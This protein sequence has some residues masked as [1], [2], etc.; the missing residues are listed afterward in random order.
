MRRGRIFLYLILIIILLGVG[1]FVFYQ[2]LQQSGGAADAVVEATAIPDLVD[3]VIVTQNVKVGEVLQGDV[4]GVIP[5]PRGKEIPEMF[6]D[7]GA[8]VGRRAKY[9]LMSGVIL[10]SS[11]IVSEASEL[12]DRGSVAASSIPH[13]F[14]ALTIPINRL[15]GVAYA[16]R[17]GDEV[18][19]IASM[20]FVD[21]DSEFQS[22][23]PNSSALVYGPMT[24]VIGM[25]G[26][27]SEITPILSAQ[28]SGG[29]GTSMGR[30]EEGADLD[31]GYFYVIPSEP[32]R[33]R[34]ATHIIIPKAKVLYVG[35]FP[36]EEE[37]EVNEMVPTATPEPEAQ[38][39]DEENAQGQEPSEPEPPDL[40]TLIVTPQ[41]AVNITYLLNSGVNLTLA[42]RSAG[43][44]T[45]IDTRT[46]TMQYFLDD[47]SIPV[48]AKLPYGF[49]PRLD[50]VEL[51]VEKEPTPTPQQ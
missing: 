45:V 24:P 44:D 33:S 46:V 2:R 49:A 25:D 19:V 39:I 32:Q 50:E 27:G 10:T 17:S 6:T 26:E 9:D 13:G 4:I 28:V 7:M 5:I 30:A 40:I 51:P 15:S 48:P 21:L 43:D 14:V 37:I 23:L 35:E 47:Y 22:I 12:P 18:I 42:L 8:V 41:E 31:E 3:I 16:L 1:G 11:M 34:L 38:Q 36:L 29:D 20:P